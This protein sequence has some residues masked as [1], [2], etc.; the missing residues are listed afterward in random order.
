MAVIPYAGEGFAM[1]AGAWSE[2][3]ATG[4]HE[5]MLKADAAGSRQYSQQADAAK[6]YTLRTASL[7][8]DMQGETGAALH[9]VLN[10]AVADLTKSA[11]SG[12][13]MGAT[14]DSMAAE[15]ESA[16]IAL[17][18]IAK[19]Y[20]TAKATILEQG[21]AKQA[22]AVA[23]GG[24]AAPAAAAAVQV[25]TETYLAQLT[26]QTEGS[27]QGAMS[28]FHQAYGGH[29]A[30][31]DA[32]VGAGSMPTSGTSRVRPIADTGAEGTGGG[33][34]DD[35]GGT[36]GGKGEESAGDGGG[37]GEEAKA[38]AGKET[39]EGSV[40]TVAD[41]GGKD[42]G[43]SSSGGGGGSGGTTSPP[44]PVT[45]GASSG[46]SS[47]GGGASSGAGAGAAPGA[48]PDLQN[49]GTSGQTA[50][51][52][53]QQFG[54]GFLQGLSG[55]QPM[56]GM[57][58]GG[59]S[60]MGMGGMG[61]MAPMGGM[62][63]GGMSPM[64]MGG[65]GMGGQ[66]PSM[67]SMAGNASGS[68]ANQI[69]NGFTGQGQT[70]GVANLLG[71]TAA[72]D[73]D[74]LSRI[75]GEGGIDSKAD[76]EKMVGK[77]VP[78][79]VT[80][81][82]ADRLG[83]DDGGGA[84]KVEPAATSG[85]KASDLGRTLAPA[86][87]TVNTGDSSG[88]AAPAKDAPAADSKTPDAPRGGDSGGSGD[89][90][91][92]D[93]GGGDSGG[94]DTGGGGGG[95]ASLPDHESTVATGGGDET[96]DPV[97][98]L[99][100]GAHSMIDAA[101]GFAHQGVEQLSAPA[102]PHPMMPTEAPAATTLSSAAPVAD[103][104]T[105]T[106]AAPAAAPAAMAPAAPA[107]MAGPGMMGQPVMGAPMMGGPVSA[108]PLAPFTPPAAAPPATAP[109]APAAPAP[110]HGSGWQHTPPSA[111]PA[112][113]VPQLSVPEAFAAA[114]ALL[115]GLP[116]MEVRAQQALAVLRQQQQ[117][118]LLF[119][120]VAVGVFVWQGQSRL[121]AATAD[122][123]SYLPHGCA[124]PEGVVLLNE[125]ADADF[126]ARWCGG[127][128]AVDKLVAAATT[129]PEAGTLSVIVASGQSPNSAIG[130]PVFV[131]P[132]TLFTK[133]AATTGAIAIRGRADFCDDAP[134]G[135][136]ARALIAKLSEKLGVTAD[137]FAELAGALADARWSEHGAAQTYRQVWLR[138]LVS[139]AARAVAA[140]QGYGDDDLAYLVNE[141][142]WVLAVDS[143]YA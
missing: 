25:E 111:P 113:A 17:N 102:A 1:I 38:D 19:E 107:A 18:T 33:K 130:S 97:T 121:I 27:V 45:P 112:P 47:S 71:K 80:D 122:G 41:S 118:A 119:G 31:L 6:G 39:G 11:D 42:S 100:S 75:A 34:S 65:M 109:A 136:Q 7:T 61:G 92:G 99:Q 138:Y 114:S 137:D 21:A 58:M 8:S 90:D 74:I 87:S 78:S 14:Y 141:F 10:T 82:I 142:T 72:G 84:A 55:Q 69:A 108:A 129:L 134:A 20:D 43:A 32:T 126:Y 30:T 143:A 135:D 139:E 104:P 120:D 51:N 76:L 124:V 23:L 3:E 127:V 60:P 53:A 22:A 63:M 13:K 35:A 105:H 15:V 57:G 54:M 49:P 88:D 103:L 101:A 94:G 83:L 67:P 37:K 123:I 9:P 28:T 98:S 62:G 115:P 36:G 116:K 95:E 128:S 106:S 2:L 110:A 73:P 64:G 79:S 140:D 44:I 59:M 93:S 66:P 12:N 24:P 52:T 132:P 125:V 16:K 26:S 50:G 133:L 68:L 91:S 131:Q 70:D 4:D 56:G 40:E 29:Q 81:A 117:D 5:D 89:S 77:T 46:G 85:D 96:A 86:E 48:A